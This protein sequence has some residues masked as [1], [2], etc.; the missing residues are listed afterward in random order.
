MRRGQVLK[1]VGQR[2]QQTGGG[3]KVVHFD[4]TLNLT[5]EKTNL[6][7]TLGFETKLCLLQSNDRSRNDAREIKTKIFTRYK[8]NS[9]K[10]IEFLE[11]GTR[12]HAPDI[13]LI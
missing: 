10:R 3:R 7:L 12:L 8:R 11:R 5:R 2:G 13:K 4:W 9:Q 6:L 1:R